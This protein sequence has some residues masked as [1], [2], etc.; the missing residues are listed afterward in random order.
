MYCELYSFIRV[1]V[2]IQFC[3]VNYMQYVRSLLWVSTPKIIILCIG[4]HETKL[5]TIYH[6]PDQNIFSFPVHY[7]GEFSC[8]AIYR[9]QYFCI[10]MFLAEFKLPDIMQ[11]F[12]RFPKIFVALL[13]HFCKM[14]HISFQ[15]HKSIKLVDQQ[16]VLLD[17]FLRPYINPWQ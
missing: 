13:R 3:T 11:Y 17:R 16:L 15:K 8:A 12:F 7:L 4:G 9:T 10:A 2:C 5:F 6:L 1:Y 14:L